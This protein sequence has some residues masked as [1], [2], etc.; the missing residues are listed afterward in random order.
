MLMVVCYHPSLG[1]KS[2]DPSVDCCSMAIMYMQYLLPKQILCGILAVPGNF[3]LCSIL[4][5][6]LGVLES[7]AFEIS[8]QLM[9]LAINSYVA[10]ESSTQAL[11]SKYF[12]RND[13]RNARGVLIRLI[14]VNLNID[15]SVLCHVKKSLIRN[16]ELNLS[17]ALFLPS[18]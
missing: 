10:L 5:G 15:V 11:C 6:R 8:K 12:G 13:P 4:L 3:M 14:Q 2:F 9:I 18:P 17:A 16:V 1:L 7:G